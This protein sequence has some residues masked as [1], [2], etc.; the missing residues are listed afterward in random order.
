MG[1][2]LAFPARAGREPGGGDRRGSGANQRGLHGGGSGAGPAKLHPGSHRGVPAGD[3]EPAR[4]K[5]GSRRP[6][7]PWRCGSTARGGRPTPGLSPSRSP[8]AGG[9]PG[10]VRLL[11]LDSPEDTLP[12]Y[13]L[14]AVGG[15][16]S[17]RGYREEQYLT[18]AAGILQVEWRWLQGEDGS[19]LYLFTD[20][21]FISPRQGRDQRDRF[22]TF[23]LGTG[24]GVRQASRLGI[25]GVEYGVAKGENPLDGRVHLR[26]DTVF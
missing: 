12:R 18:P 16:T 20:A 8:L 23:L 15:A 14:F 6:R 3:P 13:D 1:E 10:P 17:L 7:T 21:A 26:L 11:F 9:G 19:A 2:R 5:S 25:L 24:V 22:D 4:T